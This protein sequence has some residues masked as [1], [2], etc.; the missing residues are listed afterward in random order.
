SSGATLVGIPMVI[1]GRNQSISWA[2]TNLMADVQDLFFEQVRAD[3][4]LR[5]RVGDDW[6]A[7]EVRE[8]EIAVRADFPTTLRNPLA[9]LRIRVRSSRH[10]PI[11]SDMFGMFDQ[12]AALRWTALDADDSSYQA[13]FDLNYAQDWDTFQQALSQLVAPA[14][15]VLY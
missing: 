11:I 7:F 6:Q 3:D 5:Y 10:G 15:N 12:P 8:E 2:G 1:F 9:P 13:F 14:M 4:A